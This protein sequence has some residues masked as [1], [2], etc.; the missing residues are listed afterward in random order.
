ML[1]ISAV[2]TFKVVTANKNKAQEW[3]SDLKKKIG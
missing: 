1:L 3:L 2:A